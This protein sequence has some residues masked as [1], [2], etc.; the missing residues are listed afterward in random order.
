M[1]ANPL[2]GA[3]RLSEQIGCRSRKAVSFLTY[4]VQSVTSIGSPVFLSSLDRVLV[5]RGADQAQIVED[6]R[7][8]GTLARPKKARNSNRRE[9]GDD[10]HHNHDFHQREA[11]AFVVSFL[12]ITK[13]SF[14]ILLL[15]RV[16]VAGLF[17]LVTHNSFPAT[18]DQ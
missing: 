11:T 12:N 7:G 1:A 10:R 13:E 16:K 14:I 6:F 18:G 9:Q 2:F 17:G 5:H 8:L 4:L 15:L 3:V